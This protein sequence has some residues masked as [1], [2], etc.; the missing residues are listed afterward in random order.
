MTEPLLIVSTAEF[1]PASLDLFRQAAPGAVIQQFP[2]PQGAVVPADVMAK[3]DV[4]YA[5]GEPPAREIAPRLRWVAVNWAG[6]DGVIDA[7]IFK[8]GEVM[9]TSAA[10]VHAVNMGEYTLMMMLALAHRLPSAFAMMRQGTWASAPRSAFMPTEL[11]GATLGLIGYGW[12]GKEIARL[13]QAFGMKVIAL[14]RSAPSPPWGEGWGEGGNLTRQFSRDQLHT[15]LGQ[16]D[17][18]VLVV[19]I[20]PETHRMIDAPALAHMKPNAYLINIGR[21][22]TVDEPALIEALSEKRIAGAALDVF[23]EEP[24]PDSSPLWQLDNVILTPHIAGQ[25]PNY[26]PRAAGIFADNLR[27][28]IAGE[29]LVNQVDFLRGY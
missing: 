23:Q 18:V 10:G 6:V 26:E 5:Y 22:G 7:P 29:P 13:A 1:S 2:K 14:S 15:L 11:R 27:R 3:A 24:L 8:T 19:P 28:F 21:G 4:L 16:S 25:T 9:L 17:F 12:I 20:T